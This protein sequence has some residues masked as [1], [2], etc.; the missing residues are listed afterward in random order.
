MIIW[1]LR[2]IQVDALTYDWRGA[3]TLN[4][5]TLANHE[6]KIKDLFSEENLYQ[7]L[8]DKTSLWKEM[9]AYNQ[10]EV[11]TLGWREQNPRYFQH[12][13]RSIFIIT[14]ENNVNQIIMNQRFKERGKF[15]SFVRNPDRTK[16]IKEIYLICRFDDL[17]SIVR[18]KNIRRVGTAGACSE[19]G[20][21]GA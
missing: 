7:Y 1:F 18:K 3:E 19:Q 2:R 4:G 10:K 9:A 20:A 14:I 17:A 13:Y 15:L 12:F 5:E 8:R 6:A 11:D 21:D 16:F